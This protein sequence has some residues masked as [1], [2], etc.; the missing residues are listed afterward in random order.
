M[1]SGIA[2]EKLRGLLELMRPLE[3]SKSFG[4]MLI[5]ALVALS[6]WNAGFNVANFDIALF[7]TA[8]ASVA[9]LWSG[10]YALNDYMDSEQDSQH[11]IKRRRAIPSGRV[12]PKEALAFALLLL[13]LAFALSSYVWLSW[14]NYLLIAC[15]AAMLVNQFLYTAKPF[16]FKKHA[17]LDLVSG[18]LVNPLFRFYS[19]WVLFIPQFNAP[20]LLL[21]FVLGVQFGGFTLYRMSGKELE[22]K[23]GYRSSTVVFGERGV[24][25]VSYAAIG[26]GGISYIAACLLG[27][28]PLRF[29]WLAVLSLIAAPLYAKAI[30]NPK[31][32][33]MKAMYRL[34]YWH[35]LAFIAGFAVLYLFF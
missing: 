11:P 7:A 23:L 21:L 14:G 17:V 24:M 6:F 9:L 12:K 3:W 13:V 1:P 5:G 33:D 8:F 30:T 26:I 29:I 25:L 22:K 4:N 35:Y 27:I 34:V 28:L 2:G 19:G 31:K 20:L 10:L 18:S 32:M 16:E 15:V